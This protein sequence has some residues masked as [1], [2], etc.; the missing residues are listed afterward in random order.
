MSGFYCCI[1]RAWDVSK[2]M[3]ER[4][5]CTPGF[6]LKYGTRNSLISPSISNN[7]Y[8]VFISIELRGQKRKCLSVDS[9]III[10]N[11][12]TLFRTELVRFLSHALGLQ[13][14]F[15]NSVKSAQSRQRIMVRRIVS[16]LLRF[17]SFRECYDR[18]ETKII[19]A[20]AVVHYKIMFFI[21]REKLVFNFLQATLTA[22]FTG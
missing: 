21:K 22:Y 16:L 12:G 1:Y 14:L 18:T 15:L 3:Y 19:N 4:G 13:S 10:W 20:H 8:V 5:D 2:R 7:C 11:Y 9:N 17:R 6:F